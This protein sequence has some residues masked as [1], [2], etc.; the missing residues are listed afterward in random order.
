MSEYIQDNRPIAVTTPLGPNKL[1]ARGIPWA[2][3][4]LAALQFSA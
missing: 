1:A 3:G 4:H 2:R